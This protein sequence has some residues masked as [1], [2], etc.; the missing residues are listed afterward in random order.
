MYIAT[1]EKACIDGQIGFYQHLD[2]AMERYMNKHPNEFE[3]GEK[4]YVGHKKRKG[5]RRL[6]KSRKDE[7][8]N[9][10]ENQVEHKR[11]S[12]IQ[13]TLENITNYTKTLYNI[14]PSLPSSST[15]RGMSDFNT[16]LI[17]ISIIIMAFTNIFIARKMAAVESRLS[18]IATTNGMY[19]FRNNYGANGN[20]MYQ[21][22]FDIGDSLEKKYED[23]LWTW[24]QNLD[25]NQSD[26]ITTATSPPSDNIND[27]STSTTTE[28]GTKKTTKNYIP[29]KNKD[30]RTTISKSQLN[31]QTFLNKNLLE[32]SK[33]IRH[34]ELNIGQ[35]SK[36]VE[37]Q[38]R[39]IQE[40]A[41]SL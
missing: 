15:E 30:E 33:M 8:T 17:F 34:A 11:K 32:L 9:T 26:H 29:E 37:N 20:R 10:K 31:A 6:R 12:I 16:R 35:I 25:I 27:R 18:G 7:N 28:T 38:K 4:H 2:E 5:K 21:S 1:I 40:E 39:R 3:P 14:L 24:L 22:E 36:N 41:E 13:S 19:G 23:E